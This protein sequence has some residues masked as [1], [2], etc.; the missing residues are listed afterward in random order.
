MGVGEQ[1]PVRA[2]VPSVR[3]MLEVLQKL[4]KLLMEV[5][6][7]TWPILV[8]RTAILEEGETCQPEVCFVRYC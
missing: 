6:E 3:G 1:K 8:V 4:M 5:R 7:G 2:P